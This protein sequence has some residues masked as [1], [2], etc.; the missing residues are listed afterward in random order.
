MFEN[1]Y[2]HLMELEQDHSQ[3]LKQ[4]EKDPKLYL[5]LWLSPKIDRFIQIFT[6]F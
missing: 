3:A 5:L 2:K 1:D 6:A 4:E